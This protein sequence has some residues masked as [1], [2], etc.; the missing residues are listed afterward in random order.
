MLSDVLVNELFFALP[1]ADF[2]PPIHAPIRFAM[3]F[4]VHQL[5]DRRK[6]VV[7]EFVGHEQSVYGCA[8]LPGEGRL[9]VTSSKDR[10]IKLWD[11]ESSNS[12]LHTEFMESGGKPSASILCLAS[13]AAAGAS[14]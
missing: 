14:E 7:S 11:L 5:W 13:S 10:T 9:C 12:A 4:C 3:G 6:G 1:H 8:F 2:T